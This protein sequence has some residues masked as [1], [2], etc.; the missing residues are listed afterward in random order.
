M[1]RSSSATMLLTLPLEI[2]LQIWGLS[3][4]SI[5]EADCCERAVPNSPRRIPRNLF[6]PD[7]TPSA[8]TSAEILHASSALLPTFTYPAIRLPLRLLCRQANIE[9]K[10][11]INLPLLTA[12]VCDSLCLRRAMRV[13]SNSLPRARHGIELK[14]IAAF[15]IT[16]ERIA[17]P[18]TRALLDAETG[19]E[20]GFTVAMRR[21][22]VGDEV[23]LARVVDGILRELTKNWREAVMVRSEWKDVGCDGEDAVAGM[24][25]AEVKMLFEVRRLIRR[26]VVCGDGGMKSFT[27]R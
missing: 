14:R 25:T 23:R 18:R 10:Q 5:A 3:L 2:R 4:P 7:F 26:G 21:S 27:G 13:L 6:Y 1:S 17:M 15:K 9:I 22:E 12:R 19:E 20:T 16:H 8:K 24:D 11:H